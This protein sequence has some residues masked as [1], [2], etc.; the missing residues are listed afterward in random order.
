MNQ[1]SEWPTQ[2]DGV[3]AAPE[4]H[5]VLIENDEVRVVETIVRA[6]DRTPVHTHPKTV[7]VVVSEAEFIRRDDSGNVMF[8]SR[9]Q[10]NSPG[11]RQVTWSE[12]TPPHVIE[13]TDDADLIVIGVELKGYMSW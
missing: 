2:L 3:V 11:N 4:H 6:R 13:N 5:K 12:G 8:D 7:F 10:G 1:H 9:A